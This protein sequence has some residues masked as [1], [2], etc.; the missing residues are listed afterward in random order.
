MGAGKIWAMNCETVAEK[1]KKAFIETMKEKGYYT[2]EGLQVLNDKL[3]SLVIAK[4]LSSKDSSEIEKFKN[5]GR[6]EE[7]DAQLQSFY[8]GL[9]VMLEALKNGDDKRACVGYELAFNTGVEN[10]NPRKNINYLC[11]V[12]ILGCKCTGFSGVVKGDV[13]RIFLLNDKTEM[14]DDATMIQNINKKVYETIA[15]KESEN[16][17]VV[18][19]S[20]ERVFGVRLKDDEKIIDNFYGDRDNLLKGMTELVS[21]IETEAKELEAEKSAIQP[22]A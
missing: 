16:G 4:N 21:S 9:E 8:Y 5:P 13:A 10:P 15:K 22:E 14:F 19:S 6:S 2:A 7:L 20:F 11:D 18:D 3:D 17:N 12:I 1:W